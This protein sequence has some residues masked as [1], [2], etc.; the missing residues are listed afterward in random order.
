MSLL[1]QWPPNFTRNEEPE[2]SG[3]VVGDGTLVVTADHVLGPAKKASI[4]TINGIILDAE[5]VMRDQFTDIAFLKIPEPLTPIKFTDNSEPISTEHLGEK[6]CAIGNSF[7]LDISVTCGVISAT[8]VSGVGFNQ[9]EDFVQTDAAV[10]PGMSGGALVNEKGELFGLLSAIF[11][12][13]SDANIGVNFAVSSHL[14]QVV[15][16][17]FNKDGK[18]RHPRPGVLLRPSDPAKTNNI[19]GS[20]VVRIEEDSSEWKAGMRTGDILLSANNRRLKRAGAYQAAF[21]LARPNKKLELQVW[22]ENQIIE[23]TVQ[24]D[25]K[26]LN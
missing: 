16:D 12:R 21:T 18:V 23:V 8:S 17:D 7:G 25:D 2:G 14:L 13:Q 5:I 19:L 20:E 24:L 10:N 9:I 4:R 6:A 1:P 22:R 15:F 3:V 26:T 11:T